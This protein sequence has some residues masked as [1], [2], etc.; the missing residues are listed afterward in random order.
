MESG[1]PLEVDLDSSHSWRPVIKVRPNYPLSLTLVIILF[2]PSFGPDLSLKQH[3][4]GK[5]DN[6]PHLEAEKHCACTH[7]ISTE[8]R[9][10]W[11]S[12]LLQYLHS[13]IQENVL[14]SSC[15]SSLGTVL[16]LCWHNVQREMLFCSG[17]VLCS[18]V[19]NLW[20]RRLYTVVYFDLYQVWAYSSHLQW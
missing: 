12:D 18:V 7:K 2:V 3:Y 14:P 4:P 11:K 13:L 1:A 15:L 5:I 16:R 6:H 8:I 10:Q 9:V 20:S 19:L 17:M